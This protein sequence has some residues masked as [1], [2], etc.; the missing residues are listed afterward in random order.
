MRESIDQVP[1]YHSTC[2]TANSQSLKVWGR[3][4][5]DLVN[6]QPA[7]KVRSGCGLISGK[8]TVRHGEI[9]GE[10]LFEGVFVGGDRPSRF[11]HGLGHAV[12]A[13]CHRRSA[14]K[15]LSH[16]FLGHFRMLC[17]WSLAL[18]PVLSC[19]AQES[20]RALRG[21]RVPRT[22]GFVTR[23]TEEFWWLRDLSRALGDADRLWCIP[24]A[25]DFSGHGA[26]Q[27]GR[28]GRRGTGPGQRSGW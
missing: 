26:R 23:G 24:W 21:T 4:D 25:F 13:A 3:L 22:P 16:A 9:V 1:S 7:R 15:A 8:G 10:A 2:V 19:G 18:A 5:R 14:P 11:F 20:R 27:R 17:G 6:R 12:W 28:T